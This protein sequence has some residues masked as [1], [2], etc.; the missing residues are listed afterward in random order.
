M[1][2]AA[3]GSRGLTVSDLGKYLPEGTTEIVSSGAKGT[4]FVIDNCR[5]KGVDIKVYISE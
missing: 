3:I 5:E 4:K 1:K 2:A